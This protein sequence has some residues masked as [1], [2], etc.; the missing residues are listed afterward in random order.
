MFA[1][2]FVYIVDYVDG[3]SYIEPFLHLW[4]EVFF[5]VVNDGFDVVLGLIEY[6]SM[7]IHKQKWSDV[8]FLC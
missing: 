6:F 5:M 3:F 4:G 8:L 7:Y 1:F 2:E